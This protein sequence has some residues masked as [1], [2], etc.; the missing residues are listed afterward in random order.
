MK[1]VYKFSPNYRDDLS[2]KGIMFHL[3]IGLLVV[4]IATDIY[5]FVEYGAAYGIR[6][7][8][9]LLSSVVA[10]VLTE[11]V[12]CLVS[13]KDIK[14]FLCSSFPW[15]TAI[16]LVLTVQVS[17]SY[18]AV[19]ISTIIA[20]FFGKLVFG[21]FGHN[22]FNPAGVG[23]AVIASSFTGSVVNDFVAKAT[24]TATFANQG[25]FA[26]SESA[27]NSFISKFG[28]LGGMFL[29]TYQ[30]AIGETS[31]LVILLVAIYYV[32]KKVID[33]RI[34]VVYI[35]T[36]FITSLIIGFANGQ[37]IWYPIFHILTGG[38]MFGAVFMLT[39]PVTNPTSIPGRIVFAMGAAFFT[40]LIRINANLPEG[41]LYSI[42]I[43]NILTPTIEK[44][45]DSH[46]IHDEKK[47]LK[48]VII[49]FVVGFLIV[50]GMAMYKTNASEAAVNI[51]D[52]I[53]S[54]YKIGGEKV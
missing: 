24:P 54:V 34:P 19:I 16:I 22:I 36:I 45:F 35:G 37:G 17:T 51:N 1:L 4:F 25:W 27:F 13:K 18:Y 31:T 48:K 7:I 10:A 32:Y 50:F 23:R 30:G 3:L 33:Y 52:S 2:T 43:M 29:G 44:M 20:I 9:L 42:L 11:V 41:V 39:D 8:G 6:A 40:V 47:N 21:G 49:T 14:T 53:V 38:A 5:Y 28:G 12:W 46:Q 26:A 15:I